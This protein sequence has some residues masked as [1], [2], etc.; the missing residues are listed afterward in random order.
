MRL[1][2]KKRSERTWDHR[3]VKKEKKISNLLEIPTNFNFAMSKETLTRIPNFFS[4]KINNL[5]QLGRVTNDLNML[6][7][8]EGTQGGVHWIDR[9]K[10]VFSAL[11]IPRE[12]TLFIFG[13]THLQSIKALDLLQQTEKTCQRSKLKTGRTTGKSK[14]VIYGSK[15]KRGGTGFS[16]DKLTEQFPEQ[17]VHLKKLA[18]KCESAATEFI[19]SHWLRGIQAANEAGCWDT[20]SSSTSFVAALATAKNYMAAAHVDGDFLMSIHQLNM[21]TGKKLQLNDRIVQYFCFPQFGYAIGLRPSDILLFNP[22]VFHCLSDKTDNYKHEIDVH[23]TTFYVKT[24]HVG[25]NNNSV[26]LTDSEKEYYKMK[27]DR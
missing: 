3:R 13:N 12:R 16:K 15:V 14:Y 2:S 6:S 10:G 17:S 26:G 8:F 20:I 7:L 27:F 5:S 21:D 18:L 9:E 19:N 11:L 23:V 25:K 4:L 22:H 1:S 24:A